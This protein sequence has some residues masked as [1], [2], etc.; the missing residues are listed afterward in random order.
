MIRKTTIL[1]QEHQYEMRKN[2]DTTMTKRDVIYDGQ[3]L[4]TVYCR[5]M[6]RNGYEVENRPDITIGHSQSNLAQILIIEHLLKV[7]MSQLANNIK[8]ATTKEN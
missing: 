5:G 3:N 6:Q 8:K 1:G 4:G 2:P 7:V